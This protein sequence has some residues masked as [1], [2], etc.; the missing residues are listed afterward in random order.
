M[1][2]REKKVETTT[3]EGEK[4]ETKWWIADYTDG[5]GRHQ[6][7]FKYKR[8]AVAF[9]EQM[10]VAIRAGTHVALPSDLTIENASDRWLK[11][12]EANARD[13]GTIK[14]YREHIKLHILPRVGNLKLAKLTKGHVEHFRDGLISG[15]GNHPKLSRPTAAKVLRSFKSMLRA[16][17]CSHLGDG[18][19]IEISRRHQHELEQGRDIPTPQEIARLVKAAKT[20][21]LEYPQDEVRKRV[22]ALIMTAASTGLRASE[23]RGLPWRCVDLKAGE[24]HVRQR[25][26]AWLNIGSPKSKGSRRTIPLSAELV[27]ALKEW[28]LACPKGELDLVFPTSSGAVQHHK[29]MLEDVERVMK[30]A[31]VVT[32]DGTPKYALHC[33]RHF[34]ASWCINRKEDG[35]RELPVKVVQT[36]LG[37][38]SII[39]TMD[40]YG[41]LFP[42]SSDRA[43][44]DASAKALFG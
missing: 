41:H 17:G 27:L 23:L 40:V 2:V 42:Q 35:G 29:N 12:V 6:K 4:L 24:L 30:A 18:V 20:A 7:R 8:D 14:F 32:K 3:P 5:T 11:K 34:F 37:H 10:K 28:K 15:V 44:L 31:G 1:S 16:N 25:A 26:D 39:M 19:N 9:H 36:L 21:I 22:W 38:S 33:F 13:R 43:E